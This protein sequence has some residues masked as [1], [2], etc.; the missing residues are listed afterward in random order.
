MDWILRSL[1]GVDFKARSRK[2]SVIKEEEERG[3]DY[4]GWTLANLF[5]SPFSCMFFIPSVLLL[6]DLP[7][8]ASTYVPLPPYPPPNH[9]FIA[10][11]FIMYCSR[12]G[13]AHVASA[14]CQFTL[15]GC[16]HHSFTPFS[17]TSSSSSSP[18]R[19]LG[20]VGSRWP[21]LTPYWFH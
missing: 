13:T 15:A 7:P 1:R 2:P 18:Q 11:L 10:D 9:L 6:S 16:Y 8:S 19:Y 17:E 4:W 5:L 20:R 14:G 21:N 12:L 3:I